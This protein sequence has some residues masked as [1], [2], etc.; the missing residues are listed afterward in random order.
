[1]KPAPAL[2]EAVRQL[3]LR[4]GEA[5]MTVYASDFDVLDKRDQSPVTEADLAA[6]RLIEAGLRELTPDLPVLSEEGA[7]L[8]YATRRAWP[9]YWLVDPLDG[10]REFVKRN[11]EFTVNIALI[12]GGDVV[13]GVVHA[14]ALGVTY[15]AFRG[16]GAWKWFDDEAQPVAI[17]ARTEAA[18][19]PRI[20]VSR[21]HGS[22]RMQ[23]YLAALG[24]HETVSMGSALKSC[25]VAEGVADLYPRLG[26]T[27]EWDTAAAQCIVEEA[28]GKVTTTDM[29]PLRYNAKAS[30]LN[31]EF[32]VFGDAGID[33]SGF[34]PEA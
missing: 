18:R 5:I 24:P 32:L 6:H 14:P 25:L 9:R 4:A 2:L 12:E 17:H 27:S 19:P 13:L 26:P 34:L 16:G 7:D 29:Q 31:P 1:M 3:A 11:G 30:L 8:P 28:G 23:A 15:G 20:A 21:S 33:W 22:P 10:T